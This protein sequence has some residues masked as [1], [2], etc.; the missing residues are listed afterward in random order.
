MFLLP[1]SVFAH[2]V[3]IVPEDDAARTL[4][5]SLVEQLP[6]TVTYKTAGARAPAV[7]CLAEKDTKKRE[8]C[9]LEAASRAGVVGALM[10]HATQTRSG[11]DAKF[12]LIEL[13][14]G[15]DAF[16]DSH[17]APAAKWAK[18][19]GPFLKKLSTALA[20]LKKIDGPPVPPEATTPV[21]AQVT[22]PP[23]PNG[24]TTPV[25]RVE[26]VPDA[27]RVTPPKPADTPVAVVITPVAKTE[28]AV[29]TVVAPPPPR[30]RALPLVLTI[31]A[32]AAAGTAVAFTAFGTGA[33]GRL[34]SSNTGVSD[35][36]Y[37]EAVALKNE[38]NSDLSVAAGAGA[39]A[40]VLGGLAAFLWSSN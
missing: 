19:A 26:P 12:E 14:S 11:V 3:L 22:T 32:V 1:G 25:A 9:V 29:T 21:A 36:T 38:A 6:K 20:S 37:T 15:R 18:S 16:R 40:V 23:P 34:E 24:T 39:G 17:K 28:P 7:A 31:A 5:D 27:A 35:Y 13:G 8:S 2:G 33:K 4:M 30:S 10:V